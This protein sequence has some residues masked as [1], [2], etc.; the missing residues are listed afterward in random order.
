M[1]IVAD[2]PIVSPTIGGMSDAVGK[3]IRPELR[4]LPRMHFPDIDGKQAVLINSSETLHDAA[5]GHLLVF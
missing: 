1:K 5:K 2:R 4:S 3:G